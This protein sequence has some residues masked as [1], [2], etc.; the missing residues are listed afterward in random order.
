MF[1][2]YYFHREGKICKYQ[3]FNAEI[4]ISFNMLRKLFVLLVLKKY[5]HMLWLQA[6]KM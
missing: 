3:C 6:V 5:S 4:R 2:F 1:P